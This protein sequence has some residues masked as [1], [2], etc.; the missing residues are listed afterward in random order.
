MQF[1]NYYQ[2]YIVLNDDRN[3]IRYKGYTEYTGGNKLMRNILSEICQ[4][5]SWFYRQ[6][7]KFYKMLIVDNLFF[8]LVH[9]K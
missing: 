4:D 8:F 6:T 5:K 9:L 3:T 2:A 7:I 1:I